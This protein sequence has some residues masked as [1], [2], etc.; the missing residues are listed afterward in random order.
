MDAWSRARPRSTDLEQRQ[1]G[2]SVRY[3]AIIQHLQLF[4]RNVVHHNIVSKT[5]CLAG[6]II[7]MNPLT[8]SFQQVAQS[9]ARVVTP[10]ANDNDTYDAQ[11]DYNYSNHSGCLRNCNSVVKGPAK[12]VNKCWI[13]LERVIR[14]LP[15]IALNAAPASLPRIANATEAAR[16][17]SKSTDHAQEPSAQ[18]EAPK[19]ELTTKSTKKEKDSTG[20]AAQRSKIS[21]SA[22]DSTVDSLNNDSIA[23]AQP[24]ELVTPAGCGDENVPPVDTKMSEIVADTTQ[25]EN[26]DDEVIQG[27]GAPKSQQPLQTLPTNKSV[28]VKKGKVRLT[29]ASYKS[30]LYRAT[31]SC[32]FFWHHSEVVICEIPFKLILAAS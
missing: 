25:Q 31:F 6:R 16:N 19:N 14:N 22:Q 23:S 11:F 12:W 18:A 10:Q 30:I 13:D 17:S 4:Y 3:D 15:N 9:M 29:N 8:F 1:R 7:D 28:A 5:I 24:P 21:K 32:D 2:I 20:H 27:K 26:V